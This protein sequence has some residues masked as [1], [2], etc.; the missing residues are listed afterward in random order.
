MPQPQSAT[1]ITSSWPAWTF[2]ALAGERPGADVHHHRQPLAGDRVEHLLHQHEALAGGE[3]GDPAAGDGE[4]LADGGGRVLALRLDEDER[5]APEVRRPVHDRGVEAA[6]HRGRAG[7]RIGA[8]RLADPD[9]DVDDG[10]GAVAR[11]RD[12][13]IREM[14]SVGFLEMRICL[15]DLPDARDSAH[16]D[17]AG[18]VPHDASSGTGGRS[19]AGRSC[20]DGT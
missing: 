9:L 15:I 8:G 10:L 20:P 19:W 3:V 18:A 12:P 2:S 1:L 5:V 6:A 17:L 16:A 7:D 14:P 13:G 4:A 11:G